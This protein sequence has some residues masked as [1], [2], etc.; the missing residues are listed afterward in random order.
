MD[1]TETVA[2]WAGRLND[3]AQAFVTS[4]SPEK[5]RDIL[6]LCACVESAITAYL[7]KHKMEEDIHVGH[8]TT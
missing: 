8:R 4:G 1:S 2:D 3:K 6:V 5:A 7:I